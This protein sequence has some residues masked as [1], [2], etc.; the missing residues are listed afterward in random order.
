[1]TRLLAALLGL[2]GLALGGA[3]A[4]Y[5]SQLPELAG[6]YGL[7]AADRLGDTRGAVVRFAADAERAANLV[8][9]VQRAV[10]ELGASAGAMGSS[11]EELGASFTSIASAMRRMGDELTTMGT[12]LR[13]LVGNGANLAQT[14]T[15]LRDAAT[16]LDAAAAQIP[17][18]SRGLQQGASAVTEVAASLGT[19]PLGELTAGV[20]EVD[21]ELARLETA[22]RDG[23]AVSAARLVGFAVSGWIGFHGLCMLVIA[24]ALGRVRRAARAG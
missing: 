15:E 2:V 19:V 4:W 10:A 13:P 14:A 17:E 12:T 21:G 1:M 11:L 18:V 6:S 23:S 22:L 16:R 9:A 7:S 3:G 24:A 20:G 8:P 5:S